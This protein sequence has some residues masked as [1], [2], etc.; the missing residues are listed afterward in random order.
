MFSMYLILWCRMLFKNIFQ[1][2]IYLNN[3]F[4]FFI[5]TH[6]I[7]NTFK[8]IFLDFFFIFNTKISKSSRS[9]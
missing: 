4:I 3:I 8:V 9:N 1:L 6:E 5:S 7:K 2:K